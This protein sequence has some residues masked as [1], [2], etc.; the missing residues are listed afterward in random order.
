MLSLFWVYAFLMMA[1]AVEVHQAFSLD[2]QRLHEHSRLPHHPLHHCPEFH[3]P[4]CPPAAPDYLDT[5]LRDLVLQNLA[6]PGETRISDG[7]R[8]LRPQVQKPE[9]AL[10][11]QCCC[12]SS[13]LTLYVSSSFPDSNFIT[14]FRYLEARRQRSCK[15]VGYGK[16]S[17]PVVPFVALGCD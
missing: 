4:S 1:L 5:D 7:P 13:F 10:L 14:F 8:D 16:G 17:F 3:Q 11:P 9:L 6:P 15:F 2:L 12:G